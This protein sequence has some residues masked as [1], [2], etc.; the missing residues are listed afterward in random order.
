M[1]RLEVEFG[2]WATAVKEAAAEPTGWLERT[3]AKRITVHMKDGGPTIEGLL[4]DAAVDGL[5]LRQAKILAPNNKSLEMAGEV[6]VPRK[7]VMF[8]QLPD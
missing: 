5:V 6:W 2:E 1:G 3:V 7:Q 4:V 8:T